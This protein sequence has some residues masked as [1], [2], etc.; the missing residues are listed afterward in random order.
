MADTNKPVK[1]MDLSHRTKPQQRRPGSE[2]I[3][4]YKAIMSL[5][6][7][8]KQ[9]PEH[10]F[11]EGFLRMF[12]GY[13]THPDITI[14]RWVSIAGTPFSEVDIINQNG[15]VLFT[16]PPIYERKVLTPELSSG[17]SSISAVA[18]TYEK[19]S[20]QSPYRAEAF[21]NN[22]L[23]NI[24]KTNNMDE[25]RGVGAA[26]FAQIFKRYNLTP[27]WLLDKEHTVA[28]DS[29]PKD[30]PQIVDEEPL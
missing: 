23:N 22:Q 20:A 28:A 24:N 9:F 15:E 25:Y 18:A 19:L 11:V 1:P 3:E 29:S 30:K 21:L 16:V 8:N 7:T 4:G 12:A 13:E 26:R 17:G 6:S 5:N 14:G 2:I 27:A 10:L